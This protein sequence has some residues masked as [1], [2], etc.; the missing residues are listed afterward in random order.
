MKTCEDPCAV[1]HEVTYNGFQDT[2]PAFS[3]KVP[4]LKKPV[5][6][7]MKRMIFLFID[8]IILFKNKN[9]IYFIKK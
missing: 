7:L 1:R 8:P 5:A 9:K 3:K 2:K 6:A 4:I